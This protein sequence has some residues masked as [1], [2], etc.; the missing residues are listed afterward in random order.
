MSRSWGT[1]EHAYR[2]LSRP[3]H[4]DRFEQPPDAQDAHH[5][6][7]VVSEHIKAHF[8]TD[9]WEGSGQEVAGPIQYLSV[10]NGCSTVWRHLDFPW[11]VLQLNLHRVEDRFMFPAFQPPLFTR[12]TL[13]V[14][15]AGLAVR[16]PINMH[17][18]PVFPY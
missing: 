7:E 2:R 12:R 16:E 18:H 5:S 17:Q 15:C 11:I 13:L 10:P 9:P 6:L 8:S 14:H 4:L 3:F 1:L